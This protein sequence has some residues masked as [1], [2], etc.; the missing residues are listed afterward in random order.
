MEENS[1]FCIPLATIVDGCII[2]PVGSTVRI[3]LGMIQRNPNNPRKVFDPNKLAEVADSY[4]RTGD[5]EQ[6]IPVIKKD[7]GKSVV[8]NDGERRWRAAKIAQLSCVS[9]FIKPAMSEN[10]M[11][12][13][14]FKA[15]LHRESFTPI[16]E[17][18]GYRD[19]MQTFGWS[20]TEL[21][22]EVGK[23]Q[24]SISQALKYLNLSDELQELLLYGKIE[25]GIALQLATFEKQHQTIMLER[26]REAVKANGKPIHPNE[27]VRILRGE[28]ERRKISPRKTR[29][30]IHVTHAQLVARHVT[31]TIEQLCKALGELKEI[32]RQELQTLADPN[33]IDLEKDLLDLQKRIASALRQFERIV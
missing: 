4:A 10:D 23:E 3:P 32:G 7:R 18:M 1:P 22:R 28:A 25:K 9:C 21:A 30:R 20:Q 14:S 17:A 27:A 29:G 15:N 16:E 19:L 11:L 8:I 12:L 5:V 13:S 26:I 2:D 24:C 31:K 33:P 6:P